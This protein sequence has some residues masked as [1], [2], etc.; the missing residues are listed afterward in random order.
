MRET[1]I[2]RTDLIAAVFIGGMEG[3]LVEHE[4]FRRH[5]ADA[6]V[7]PVASPGGA[8]R[9]LAQQLEVC[10]EEDRRTVDYAS[11]FS[12]HLGGLGGHGKLTV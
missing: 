11:L 6:V 4:M 9:L 7:L 2:S 10:S 8:A 12:R 1:M 3:V 5:H